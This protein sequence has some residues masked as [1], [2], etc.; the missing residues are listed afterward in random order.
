MHTATY[1]VAVASWLGNVVSPD[2]RR[3][4]ASPRWLGATWE[5]AEVLRYGENPHQRAALYV[6]QQHAATRPRAG[7][8]AAR[9]GDVVQQLRRRR[10][11]AARGVRPHRARR[12]DH[13]ARQ[14]VRHRRRR[15]HR[16]G[17]PQ[18]ATTPT[19]SRRSAASSRPTA[20]SRSRWPQPGRRDLHRGRRGPG[21]D[22]DALEM[23]TREEEPAPAR[24]CGRPGPR[25]HRDPPGV[26]RHAAAGDRHGRRRRATTPRRGPSPAA[27]PPTTATLRDLV[28]A[29]RAVPL[30]EEQRDPARQGRRRRRRRHG[31]GQP[32]RLLP[33][34]RLARRRRAGR[35]AR[36]RR[37]TRSSPSP[38]ASR[39]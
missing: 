15:R 34:R 30:G 10:R 22:D 31:P 21:F 7:R 11:R 36:S 19:R 29:W 8:A 17:A 23:L 24:G 39:C 5:R 4:P 1:D 37:P 33:A 28:F 3:A 25:R 6:T 14:P 32:R 18:G 9:Q 27:S 2:R 13:Q 12:R 26:R 20:R 35:A 16:R 38:T